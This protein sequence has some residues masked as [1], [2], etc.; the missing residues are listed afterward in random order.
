MELLKK[1]FL[2]RL[3]TFANELLNQSNRHWE[4]LW[5]VNTVLHISLLIQTLL[6]RGFNYW[7]RKIGEGVA[8]PL[9]VLF[10]E[11]VISLQLF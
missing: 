9:I 11:S 4:K 10:K 1:K 5:T 2:E 3:V 8:E 6:K 7:K